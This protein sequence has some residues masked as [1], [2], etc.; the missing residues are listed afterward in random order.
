MIVCLLEIKFYYWMKHKQKPKKRMKQ[1]SLNHIYRYKLYN[2]CVLNN[3]RKKKE[4]YFEGKTQH[5]TTVDILSAT[6]DAI[7]PNWF[8]INQT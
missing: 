2:K 4:A 8:H 3:S 1:F 7:Q 5:S 6:P